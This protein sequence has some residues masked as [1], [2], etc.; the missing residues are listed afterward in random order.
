MPQLA[1][2]C[3]D[4][5]HRHMP[6]WE[7]KLWNED[8]F[9]VDAVPYVREAY[10]ARKYAFV[11]DYVRL[12]ALEKEGGVYLDV[13]FTIFKP[14]DALLCHK[15]FAGFEGSKYQPV[16]MGVCASE[17]HGEWVSEML[18]AYSDRHFTLPD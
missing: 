3:I 16:M 1:K 13:D 4:S 12:Y 7:Y 11:S 15:A 8:N 17:A 14:F 9:E 10:L 2:D 6:D 18:N 5:W